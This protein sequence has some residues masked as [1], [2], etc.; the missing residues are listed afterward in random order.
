MIP[1]ST[2]LFTVIYAAV[3]VYFY[4]NPQLKWNLKFNQPTDLDPILR[5]T[6]NYNAIAVIF[7]KPPLLK[8]STPPLK[9]KQRHRCKNLQRH[10]Y[11]AY[12]G[13]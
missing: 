1:I 3:A 8:L 4:S 13:T 5:P 9:N 6:V 12:L 11:I 10:E 7:T 2:V